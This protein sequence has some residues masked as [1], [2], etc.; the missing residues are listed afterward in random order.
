ML[1][2]SPTATCSYNHVISECSTVKPKRSSFFGVKTFHIYLQKEICS[3]FEERGRLRE[4]DDLI[5]AGEI[6]ANKFHAS[7]GVTSVM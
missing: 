4:D 1:M 3:P 2:L 5:A 6:N 7:S